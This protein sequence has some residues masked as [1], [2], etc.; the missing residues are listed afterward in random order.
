MFFLKNCPILY[1]KSS[2]QKIDS[3]EN[4][5]TNSVLNFNIRTRF[6]KTI[7]L[8]LDCCRY[9]YSLSTKYLM[10]ISRLFELIADTLYMLIIVLLLSVCCW[11]LFVTAKQDLNKDM[12][13][14][15]LGD[16]NTWLT[17][18]YIMNKHMKMTREYFVLQ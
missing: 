9:Y 4:F 12:N 16:N 14:R 17:N 10:V 5:Y 15:S 11:F 13:L 18:N 2:F 7:L 1:S 6:I 8:I 3:A